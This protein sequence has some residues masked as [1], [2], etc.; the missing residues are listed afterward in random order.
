MRRLGYREIRAEK[1]AARTGTD[2][3]DCVW[4]GD[5]FYADLT[6]NPLCK[7]RC[8]FKQWRHPVRQ[9]VFGALYQHLRVFFALGCLFC[10]VAHVLLIVITV[11]LGLF[12][13]EATAIL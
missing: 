10:F 8:V 3:R 6:Q 9:R 11:F 5:T 7:P 4:T 12:A 1:F 13:L 2:A